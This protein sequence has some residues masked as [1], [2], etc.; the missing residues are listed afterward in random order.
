MLGRGR[1]GLAQT[2]SAASSSL[3]AS[4]AGK[5]RSTHLSLVLPGPSVLLIAVSVEIGA[6]C[7]FVLGT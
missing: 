4:L 3:L 5:V 6:I 1:G 2:M 7:T